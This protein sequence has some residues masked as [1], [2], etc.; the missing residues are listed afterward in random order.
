MAL[1]LWLGAACVL[2]LVLFLFTD[3]NPVLWVLARLGRSPAALAGRVV[4]LTGASSGIGE[5]LAV[6]LARHGARLAL[7]ARRLPELER[8]RRRCLEAGAPADAV[9]VLPLDVTA[10][11]EHRPALARLLAHFGRLD[12]LINNA[13]RT[14]RSGWAIT[15]PDVDRQLFDVNVFAPVELTRAALPELLARRGGHVVVMSSTAGTCPVPCS[16]SYTGSK[17]A[18][19]GYFGALRSELSGAGLVVTLLCPGPTFSDMLRTAF[20]DRPGQV[21]GGEMAPSD[22]RMSAERCAQLCAVA[23]GAQLAEA[24]IAMQPVLLFQ[25]LNHYTPRLVNLAF[26]LFGARIAMQLRDSKSDFSTDL[27]EE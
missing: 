17:H 6:E 26:R 3:C 9:L 22:R 18:L 19:H 1:F 27:K 23:I 13:G 20:V 12:V 25:Y 7:S 10:L 16:G 15:H 24:W 4:W 8:V 11:D 21:F 2:L 5:A 14:Q